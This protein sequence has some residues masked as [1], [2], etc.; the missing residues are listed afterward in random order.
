SVRGERLSPGPVHCSERCRG[1]ADVRSLAPP[2]LSWVG[3]FGARFVFGR[4]EIG[5]RWLTEIQGCR[6]HAHKPC[7][8]LF[9][10]PPLSIVVPLSGFGGVSRPNK[11][12]DPC[13]I[14]CGVGQPAFAKFPLIKPRKADIVAHL[15]RVLLRWFS[16]FLCGRPENSAV[17]LARSS[18]G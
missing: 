9:R 4:A 14:Q 2:S 3:I 10:R 7:R 17:M 13:H 8:L 15:D 5:L 18:G 1:W 12:S 16:G 11:G 6:R